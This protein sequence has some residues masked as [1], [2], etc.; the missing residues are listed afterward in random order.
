M[1]RWL[2]NGLILIVTFAAGFGLATY[3]LHRKAVDSQITFSC[4]GQVSGF[5]TYYSSSDG[6][7]LRY[8]CY[9][10]SSPGEAERYLQDEIR[11]NSSVRWPDGHQSNV[12]LLERTVTFD[13]T[14]KKTGE[15]AVLDDGEVLWTDGP[16]FHLIYAPS[17]QYALLF[18]KSRSWAWEDCWTIPP[19]DNASE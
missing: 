12:Q 1:R 8:G 15:R 3:R 17:V 11:P 10:H 18:E 2:I 4:D 5:R 9:E 14:G 6:Q 16:R 13:A 7:H 19:R